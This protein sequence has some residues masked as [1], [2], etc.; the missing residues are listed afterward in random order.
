MNNQE[1][2][3]RQTNFSESAQKFKQQQTNGIVKVLLGAGLGSVGLGPLGAAIAVYGALQAASDSRIQR[4]YLNQ[5]IEDHK[6]VVAHYGTNA[7][8]ITSKQLF[9]RYETLRNKQYKNN[10]YI[11]VGALGIG[12]LVV[13][14]A[15]IGV[16]CLLAAAGIALA[17]NLQEISDQPLQNMQ[18]DMQTLSKQ[19]LT[20]R[21]ENQIHQAKSGPQ[22]ILKSTL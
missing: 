5:Q 19:I 12:A 18:D 8:Q 22:S 16:V 2:M 10:T 13:S 4:I 17:S 9:T 3:K 6:K 15:P 14:F 11:S 20:K 1:Y 7:Q 21:S